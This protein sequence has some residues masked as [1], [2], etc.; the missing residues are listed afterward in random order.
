VLSAAF[1]LLMVFVVRPLLA[2]VTATIE[3]TKRP[4]SKTVVLA[5]VLSGIMLSALAT[6]MIGIHAIFGAFLFGVIMP[7]ESDT[8][9][10]ATTRMRDVTTTLLLP[11]FFVYVGLRT[12][13]GLLGTDWALWGWCLVIM[14]VAIMGKWGGSTA[15]ARVTGLDWRQSLSLG[16]LMSCRGLTE[17]V[18]L[19]IGLDLGVISPTMFAMLVIMALVST[20]M[21]SPA[22]TVIERLTG[23]VK[24]RA[25][26]PAAAAD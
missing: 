23:R 20:A 1:F 2:R 25:R 26:V 10:Q 22:L 13:F 3:R 12:K 8:V 24:E 6:D 17:L 18:V 11:L 9:E 5:V 21:T 14:A 4:V 15:A 16:A 7:R 19:N